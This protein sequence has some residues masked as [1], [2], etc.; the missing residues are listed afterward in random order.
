MGAG[1]NPPEINPQRLHPQLVKH[2]E[3][4][5][6]DVLT[7]EITTGSAWIMPSH[8]FSSCYTSKSLPLIRRPKGYSLICAPNA[9]MRDQ[10]VTRAGTGNGSGKKSAPLIRAGYL[11]SDSRQQKIE[12]SWR[13]S[14][15]ISIQPCVRCSQFG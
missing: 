6:V 9:C 5:P 11:L 10:Y 15:E 3:E 14:C 1:D 7:P 12:F 8:I 13:Y 4:P 2:R